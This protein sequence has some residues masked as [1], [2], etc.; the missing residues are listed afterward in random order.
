MSSVWLSRTLP[1]PIVSELADA[2]GKSGPEIARTPCVRC[3]WS[4]DVGSFVVLAG[5]VPCGLAH[6]I[7]VRVGRTGDRRVPAR[8]HPRGQSGHFEACSMSRLTP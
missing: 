7:G 3:W 4:W 6:G 5:A 1:H 2:S 8:F